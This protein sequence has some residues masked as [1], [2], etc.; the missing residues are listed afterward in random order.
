MAM[1]LSWHLSPARY[2]AHE[3]DFRV[4]QILYL[5]AIWGNG[6]VYI[7]N[8]EGAVPFMYQRFAKFASVGHPQTR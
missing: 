4:E 8:N 2:A 1:S 6:I 3:I 7:K 5:T